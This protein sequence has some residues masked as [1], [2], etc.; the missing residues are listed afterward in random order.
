MK[1]YPLAA[2]NS[3]LNE[4][5]LSQLESCRTALETD[6]LAMLC[7]ATAAKGAALY[8][9]TEKQL[10]TDSFGQVPALKVNTL[11]S[12]FTTHNPAAKRIDAGKYW[13]MRFEPLL[14]LPVLLAVNKTPQLDALDL[15]G[16]L[17]AA[18]LKKL[19]EKIVAKEQAER[20]NNLLEG[21]HVGCWEWDVPTGQTV[22]D[23]RWAEMLGFTLAELAP[24]S[25]QTWE[26]LAHPDDLQLAKA[27]LEA[28]FR[29]ETTRYEVET[30]MKH[31]N[32]SW[33]WILDRGKL[34]SR[35]PDGGPGLMFG[36]HTDITNLKNAELQLSAVADN[37]PGAIFRYQRFPDGSDK[38]MNMSQ[39]SHKLWGMSPEEAMNHN[40]KIWGMYHPD[41][42]P[43]VQASINESML[44]L[45]R[46]E[47]EW[48]MMH[49]DGSIRWE[50]GIGQPSRLPDGSTVWD[51]IILDITSEKEISLQLEINEKRF[52]SLV[53]NSNDVVVILSETGSA[54]YVSPSIQHVLGYTVDEALQL[55]LFEILHPEDA[56]LV[57]ERFQVC[58]QKPGEPIKGYTSRVK[59]KDGRWRWLEA[60][61]TNRLAD[62]LFNGIIDNFRDVT[63]QHEAALALQQ[64]EARRKKAQNI[65]K[66][67]YWQLEVDTKQWYWGE[68]IHQLLGFESGA[69]VSIESFN[70]RIHPN[71][72][73][74]VKAARENALNGETSL[75]CTYRLL[76]NKQKIRWLHE[77]G[78]LEINESGQRIFSG[79]L[80]D[81]TAKKEEE[82]Q[83]RLFESIITSTYD[84]VFISDAS[85]MQ[86]PGPY[87]R[88]AN[89]A[90]Y[91][92]SGYS[93]A[94]LI[95]QPARM[96]FDTQTQPEEIE[97]LRKAVEAKAAGE[98]EMVVFRKNKQPFW[99]H[100]RMKPVVDENGWLSHW[101]TL[102]QDI[103]ERKQTEL[104]QQLFA[105]IAAYF[106]ANEPMQNTMEKVLARLVHFGD[107]MLAESWLLSSDGKSMLMS[108]HY[109]DTQ[110]G[111]EFYT[112]TNHIRQ[113]HRGNGLIGK[114]WKAKNLIFKE[115]NDKTSDFLRLEAAQ[116]AGLLFLIA[117]PLIHLNQVLGVVVIGV[118]RK[119]YALETLKKLLENLGREFGLEVKRKLLELELSQM[120]NAS[121]DIICITNTLGEFTRVNPTTLE[122]FGFSENEIIGKSILDFVHPDDRHIVASN[123]AGWHALQPKHYF[124]NRFLT[125][126]GKVLWLA[127]TASP[128]PEEGLIY[129]VAK[130]ISEKKRLEDLLNKATDMSLIGGWEAD[131]I[132]M[133]MQWS[134]MTRQIH[135]VA[136]DYNPPL[137]GS[138]LF[139]KLEEDKQKIITCSLE[140]M[141]NGSSWDLEMPIITA[142]GN[143][144]WVRV[145]GQAELINGK[146][147][148][149]FGSFQDIDARKRTELAL[150][151]KSK[152]LSTNSA[153]VALF[154]AFENWQEALQPA[155][156]LMGEAVGVDRAYYFENFIHPE[157]GRLYTRQLREYAHP[158]VSAQINNPDYQS[159]PLDEHPEFLQLALAGKAFSFITDELE[160]GPTK[161]LL[162]EQDIQS[163]LQIPVI[164]NGE[165]VGYIGFD[166][167]THP[168]QWTA[169][170]ISFL[171]GL[172][173][174]LSVAIH[175]KEQLDEITNAY[176]ERNNILES[177]SEGFIMLNRSW[178][179]IYWN[180]AAE[181]ILQAPKKDRLGYNIWEV[182]EDAVATEFYNQYQQVME[183]GIS[184]RFE[185]YY[186]GLS[187]WVE[188]SAY[189]FNNGIS[190]FFR[191]VTSRRHQETALRLANERFE[192]VSQ[193]TD[194]AI[195]DWDLSNNLLY[196]GDGF[197]RLFGEKLVQRTVDISEWEQ[198][199]HPNDLQ[200]VTQKLEMAIEQPVKSRWEDE[201][202]YARADGSYAYVIDRAA[203]MRDENGQATRLIGA[204]QDIS[205]RKQQEEKL[206]QL[207]R[208]LEK[209]LR[210][211]AISNAELEQFAYVASHDLQEP[212][213]MVTSFLTQLEKKY[214]DKLDDKAHQYIH[215]ATDG[216]FR[217][218]QII[219]DLLEFSRVGRSEDKIEPI[220]LTSVVEEIVLLYRKKIEE[221]K[222]QINWDELPVIKAQKTPV[223]QLFQNLLSNALKYVDSTQKPVV[224]LYV[225]DLGNEWQFAI[226][227]NGIGIA[228]EF[229]DKIF[230]IF[231]RL[232]NREAYSGT[233]MGL[234]ICKKIIDNL[235]GKIW[236]KSE[237]GKGSTF[238]FTLPKS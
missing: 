189:P 193:A 7:H 102:I 12:A 138:D 211:L 199:I 31:K 32:G 43:Q 195:W 22:F 117:V 185:A 74:K 227:D 30:R 176:A 152:L 10:E 33:V 98:A 141:Q 182:Y 109:T 180:H 130:D 198:K 61:I 184:T 83:L 47:A 77:I 63:E 166:Q 11:L 153:I 55:N 5:Q 89:E 110:A 237:E 228:P 48:R 148:R 145:I 137:E 196:R 188:V 170:E 165:F 136:P 85:E 65:A 8:W 78:E 174:S 52:K 27:R 97:K 133:K 46:W 160:D 186:A 75:N 95:G 203:I 16:R 143:E 62:P 49:P 88:F 219:L 100:I 70:K 150:A 179:I 236:V 92:L 119:I 162:V 116:K 190:I 58:L 224:N 56:P 28:Y 144:K 1:V 200:R 68:E 39:G 151:Q 103:S 238:Y 105:D 234:A 121:P 120:F 154:L 37:I 14:G 111:H 129:A 173:N 19:G 99:A 81:I 172:C 217:M 15:W 201:Y 9:L 197:A 40:E 192:L 38:L 142:K 67:G 72:W 139:I 104:Q 232:H 155:L 221:T 187:I 57:A 90:F 101:I 233:G 6:W 112:A 220:A 42:L 51:S 25:L 80:Q 36:T 214:S 126:K 26:K 24:I 13:L 93:E 159:I 107:F 64:A 125:K 35:T 146:C 96:I 20:L 168:R 34:V 215:F 161:K 59:H 113:F 4:H 206:K 205:V 135:E 226:Q 183:M 132:Q 134:P 216:A 167:C 194:E 18:R 212:L 218:R 209:K 202:R 158:A 87:I 86:A 69:E 124:E 223:R 94:E 222:A 91:K 210:E 128:A 71:D 115:I 181:A 177:I 106:N 73:P 44:H 76:L 53:E 82:A 229:H 84:A 178:E 140:A 54:T 163:I 230:I 171:E 66:L 208:E 17:F 123:I 50:R 164:K 60:T 2:T 29:G 23:D 175:R 114:C 157:N 213:R 122:L 191:D 231:Q 21:T 204:V 118:N 156:Q 149:L 108:A 45:S 41:D 147:T 225:E 131:L 127:W 235:G 79:T 3:L 207:N 169:E